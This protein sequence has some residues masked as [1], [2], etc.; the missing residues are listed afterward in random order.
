MIVV[1]EQGTRFVGNYIFSSTLGPLID[2]YTNQYRFKIWWSSPWPGQYDYDSFHFDGRNVRNPIIHDASI[3]FFVAG[4]LIYEEEGCILDLEELEFK[5]ETGRANSQI[6][7]SESAAS[8]WLNKFANSKI[9]K[10]TMTSWKLDQFFG[11]SYGTNILDTTTAAEHFPVLEHK[12]GAGKDLK[13]EISFHNISVEFKP[14]GHEGDDYYTTMVLNVTVSYKDMTNQWVKV[15]YDENELI[16]SGTAYLDQD[17]LYIAL[18]DSFFPDSGVD[19][20]EPTFY[21]PNSTDFKFSE[22]QYRSFRKSLGY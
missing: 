19:K 20:V 18:I 11:D 8:C 17:K 14:F 13:F 3:D 15:L 10:V 21:N 2:T 9:G 22:S 4:D 5:N 1:I 12:L 16:V 6:V 7:L